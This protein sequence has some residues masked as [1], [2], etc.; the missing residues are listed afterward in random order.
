MLAA[1]FDTFY[2]VTVYVPNRLSG[3]WGGTGSVCG[4]CQAPTHVCAG[5]VWQ[6]QG[7][8]GLPLCTLTCCQGLS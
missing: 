4:T 6:W 8:Y 7:M 5:S 2:L 3:A 1:E